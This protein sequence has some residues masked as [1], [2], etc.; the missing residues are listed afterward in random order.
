MHLRIYLGYGGL[1]Q[2]NLTWN[3][4]G[5]GMIRSGVKGGLA[6]SRDGGGHSRVQ[7]ERAKGNCQNKASSEFQRSN[8]IM[9]STVHH[10]GRAVARTTSSSHTQSHRGSAAGMVIWS[11]VVAWWR[12]S[13]KKIPPSLLG[14]GIL[15]HC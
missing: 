3:S 15:F 11:G 12:G 8:E 6:G 13:R 9:G 1:W 2:A 7:S 4:Y 5:V 10:G 14:L